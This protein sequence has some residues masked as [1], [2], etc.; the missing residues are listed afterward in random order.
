MAQTKIKLGVTF[1]WWLKP[2]LLVLTV[3]CVMAGT[4]PDEAK[5][6]AKIKRAMRVTVQ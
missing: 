5:L 1:A 2:Y 4:L 6:L 3:C